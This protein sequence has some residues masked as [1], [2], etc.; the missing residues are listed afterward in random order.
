MVSPSLATKHAR[1]TLETRVAASTPCTLTGGKPPVVSNHTPS[2]KCKATNCDFLLKGRQWS[3]MQPSVNPKL[4][5]LSFDACPITP[6]VNATSICFFPISLL[7]VCNTRLVSF[8]LSISMVRFSFFSSSI[9][10]KISRA[11]SPRSFNFFLFLFSTAIW[12]LPC[13]FKS[14]NVVRRARSCIFRANRCLAM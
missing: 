2:V 5:I 8:I 13:K 11:C 4:T 14:L 1:R 6:S 12:M 3:L 9:R 10:C 7:A